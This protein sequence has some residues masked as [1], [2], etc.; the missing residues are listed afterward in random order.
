MQRSPIYSSTHRWVA[1]TFN[2]RSPFTIQA[3]RFDV[4]TCRDAPE[5]KVGESKRQSVM[6]QV[7]D[8]F[9]TVLPTGKYSIS[10]HY[11]Y[12]HGWR[13]GIPPIH[14]LIVSRGRSARPSLHH[15]TH[16][17]HHHYHNRAARLGQPTSPRGVDRPLE[18]VA[19]QA[20]RASVQPVRCPV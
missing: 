3:R 5:Q 11:L 8:V 4:Q 19:V 14:V 1:S 2:G 17:H 10:L 12:D 16:H 15:F 7:E 20:V 18:R 6:E 13:K 9:G